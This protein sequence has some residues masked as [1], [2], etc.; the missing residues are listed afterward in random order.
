MSD[1]TKN[2]QPKLSTLDDWMFYCLQQGTVLVWSVSFSSCI[3][4]LSKYVSPQIVGA[5]G[6]VYCVGTV[7]AWFIW[8]FKSKQ[9]LRV[10]I[11]AG[12]FLI[13]SVLGVWL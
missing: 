5:V 4:H 13:G 1:Q 6:A 7:G 2:Q 10:K 8:F 12:T 11:A 3:T 9:A